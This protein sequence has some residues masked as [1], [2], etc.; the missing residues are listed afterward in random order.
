M[1]GKPVNGLSSAGHVAVA[2]GI[3]GG[4]ASGTGG[5]VAAGEGEAIP[6]GD[7][8]NRGEAVAGTV[9]DGVGLGARGVSRSVCSDRGARLGSKVSDGKVE[10]R[11]AAHPISN[12]TKIPQPRDGIAPRVSRDLK[13]ARL[14]FNDCAA[15]ND[16]W[17]RS[18]AD[19]RWRE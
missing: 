4:A 13:A 9:D 7:A 11:S 12:K 5:S 3:A 8:V 18:P 15:A 6:V 17:E 2:V 16:L 19:H 10:G 1:I 14:P